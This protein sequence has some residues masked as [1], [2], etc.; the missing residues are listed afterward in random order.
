MPT[1]SSNNGSQLAI[2]FSFLLIGLMAG[3]LFT[4]GFSKLTDTESTDSNTSTS[5]ARIGSIEEL[6][7]LE[8]STDDDAVLGNP[9]APVTIVEF[10][11]YQCRYCQMFHAQSFAKIKSKYIDTGKVRFIYRDYTPTKHPQ[12]ALAAQAAECVGENGD[13][14]YYKMH[15]ALFTD[16]AQWSGVE[17][18]KAGMVS[19]A[20]G[21]GYDISACLDNEK[22]AD[23]VA[24]DYT[25]A[26]GYSISGTPTFAINGHIL[27]GAWP[28]EE[29][30]NQVIP[31]DTVFYFDNLIEEAIQASK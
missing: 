16:A 21:L 24:A 26:R 12:S 31:L 9:N 10:S 20:Q 25:A 15:E 19:I 5:A 27:V 11:D 7:A 1:P 30:P 28:F 29:D 3:L 23:E 13:E 2:A 18:P 14:A 6:P 8:I 17:D 4:G 22:M